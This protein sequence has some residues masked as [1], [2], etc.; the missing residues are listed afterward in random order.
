MMTD[1]DL[2]D[3]LLGYYWYVPEV[4]RLSLFSRAYSYSYMTPASRSVPI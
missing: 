4:Y 3:E 2:A 1:G